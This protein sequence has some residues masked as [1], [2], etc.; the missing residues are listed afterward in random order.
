M[1][2][3]ISVEDRLPDNDIDAIFVATKDGRVT[4]GMFRKSR[5]HNGNHWWFDKM[6]PGG[7][8][9]N[10]PELWMESAVTH[11]QPIAWPE[12]P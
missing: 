7:P 9:H 5:L 6:N 4:I 3:W 1:G 12:L 10:F 11:W 8:G 2:T